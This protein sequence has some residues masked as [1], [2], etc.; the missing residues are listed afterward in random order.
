[1]VD[2]SSD[3]K[4]TSLYKKWQTWLKHEKHYSDHTLS[5]Y[6]TDIALF[7][8][9]LNT[10]FNDTVSIE[11]IKNVTTTDIRSWLTTF[12]NKNYTITS[13]SRYAAALRNFYKYLHKYEKITNTCMDNIKIKKRSRSLPKALDIKSITSASQQALTQGK[14]RWIQLRDYA[15]ITLIYGCG[16]RISEGLGLTKNSMN[17]DSIVVLG[18]GNKT[19]SIPMIKEVKNA[20]DLYLTECPYPLLNDS[21][22]FVGKQGKTLNP[23][24]FQ[25]QIRTIRASL[26]L[27]SYVTP[28][29]LR[30]SFAT[31][32]LSNGANLRSIQELLGHQHLSTTQI[33]TAV[34]SKKLLDSYYKSHPRCK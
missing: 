27:P 22:I 13:Y 5:S 10:H 6:S 3:A 1:M 12:I 18:K 25:R 8:N 11:I 24:V 15:F 2:F 17:G 33:Y 16:L 31:H 7:F 23:T 20:I 9:F 14:D 29:S 19:R 32:L 34:D 21:P 26:G 4:V 28:H 30:H